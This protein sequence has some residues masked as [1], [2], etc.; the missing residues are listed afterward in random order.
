[1]SAI[2]FNYDSLNANLCNWVKLLVLFLYFMY[3]LHFLTF[4]ISTFDK[5]SNKKVQ[6]VHGHILLLALT[7]LIASVVLLVGKR[8]L[9]LPFHSVSKSHTSWILTCA[10]IIALNPFLH[11]K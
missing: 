5:I 3:Y 10:L 7:I 8:N 11:L 9:K 6:E 4:L 2:R 1:M